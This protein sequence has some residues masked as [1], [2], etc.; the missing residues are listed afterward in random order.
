VFKNYLAAALRNLLRNRIHAAINLFGLSLGFA[1]ALLIALYVRDELSYDRFFPGHNDVYLVTETKDYTNRSL[2]V[3]RWDF[4]SPDLA[5]K[6]ST[7]FPQITTI[8]RAMT[9]YDPPHIR[10]DQVEAEE[11][12]FLWVDPSFFRVMPLK[13]LA[14]DAQTALVAPDSVVLTRTAARKYFGRDI[15]L[16]ELLEVNPAMGID[17]AKVSAA[18]NTPHAMRVTAVIEDLPPNSY[19]K[20]EV[21]GSSLAA[22]SKFALYDLTQDQGPFRMNAYTFIRLRPGA[23]VRQMRQE[24]SAFAAHDAPVYPPGFTVGLHL[25]PLDDLHLSPPG[26]SPISPRGDR[27]HLI[28]LVAI[29]LLIIISASFNFV[30]LMTARAAQ[31]A[32][33]T[34]V[35]KASGA[36]RS[37]LIIQFLGEA[38]IYVALAMAVAVALSEAL[39]P[40]VNSVLKQR[41]AFDYLGDPVLLCSLLLI[42]ILLGLLAGA[43]PAFFL[44]AYR[45]A[46]VLKGT[47]AQGVSGGI[48][49]RSLVTLQFAIMI[50]LGV[51][52][53]TIWRQTMFS[54]DNQLR[55]DGSSILLIDDACD[56][57]GGAFQDRVATLSG[58][59]AVA[60]AN[61]AALYDGG[62]IVSARVQGGAEVPMVSGAVDYNALQ[63]YGLQ[64]LAGR[65]FDRDHG[66]DG[67]LVEGET[68]GNP[69]I[70]INETAMRK[71]GFSFPAQAVGQIVTWNRRRWSPKPN[72]GTLGPSEIIGVSPDFG[73]DTRRNVYPQILYV[74]PISFSVLSVRL[75]GSQ[76]P[77]TLT[78]IN[79]A[80]SQT[81][82]TRI[83]QRFLSQRLQDIYS[84]VI[85]QRMAVGL[86]TALAGVIGVL[87]LLGLSAYSAAQR[88]KEIGIRKAMGA[89]R[90][91]ILRFFVWQFARPVLCANL[92]AW[93][94]AYFLM[95][96]WLDGFG[97]HV[98][99]SPL[100]FL[101]AGASA[102]LVALATVLGHALTVARAKPVHALRYE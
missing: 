46:A 59:A 94:C 47:L 54:L 93:P 41:I 26:E 12:D 68:T 70:V 16:G 24:L 52:T 38:I 101:A 1:A 60:C 13:S 10:H 34:G 69:S 57:S 20:G 72:P 40:R 63:F 62:M 5:A 15:P 95:R 100:T 44:S 92:I 73:L 97:H 11:T 81:K 75:T 19:V 23:P 56:P 82:H 77:E 37:Q 65:F 96:H 80:W 30:S 9:S 58:V 17:A 83:H 39:L 4:S 89:S 90:L 35:R 86:S 21:F 48:V 32:I 91:D 84:D 78:A 99:L 2:P 45:P 66:D 50:G 79:A 8:A 29:G 36:L 7:Q 14:G 25:T 6:L 53:V 55:V 51:T 88:T 31:R 42:T 28:A 27:S 64:P 61:E 71:L 43:Y 87:G 22:Y 102:L 85:L 67:R 74:D 3:E 98:S 33:E 49:R 76:I 18:F